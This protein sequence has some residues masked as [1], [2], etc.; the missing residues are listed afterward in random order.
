MSLI[1]LG[2]PKGFPIELIVTGADEFEARDAIINLIKGHFG[3]EQ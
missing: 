1:L 2:A 3:E